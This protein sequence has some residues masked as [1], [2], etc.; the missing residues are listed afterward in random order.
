M[1]HGVRSYGIPQQQQRRL[2]DQMRTLPAPLE[3]F[4]CC[5]DTFAPPTFVGLGPY[6][7]YSV[8]YRYTG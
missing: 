6:Q 7:S 8:Q 2:D 3:P 5:L 4:A 1:V